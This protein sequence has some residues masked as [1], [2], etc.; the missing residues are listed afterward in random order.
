MSNQNEKEIRNADNRFR[1][2]AVRDALGDA[3]SER[4]AAELGDRYHDLSTPSVTVT[5]YFDAWG[6]L[7]VANVAGDSQADENRFWDRLQRLVASNPRLM[8]LS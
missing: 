3:V 1:K 2:D 6:W 4:H 5:T 8:T 7:H